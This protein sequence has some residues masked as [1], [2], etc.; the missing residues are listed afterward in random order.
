MSQKEPFLALKTFRNG[1]I[2]RV[3][4]FFDN[5]KLIIAINGFQKKTQ[6]TP[7]REIMRAK[8]IKNEYESDK[9]KF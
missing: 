8:A 7:R 9:D 1:L 6:K 3:F 2:Y 5:N 4:G